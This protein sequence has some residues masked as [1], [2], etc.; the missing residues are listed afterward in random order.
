MTTG[1]VVTDVRTATVVRPLPRPLRLGQM[2]VT[3]REYSAVEV[4]AG[5]GLRGKA[6]CLSREAP[7]ADIVQRL[8]AEHVVGH[9]S[10]DIEAIWDAALRGSAIVGRVGLVR[11]ALGLVDIALWDIAAQRA[12]VPLWSLLGSGNE[13]RPAMLVAAYPT[14][15]RSATEI[16]DEV[17][18]H[19]AQGWPL[20]KISR[21]PDAVLMR[22]VLAQLRDRL[23]DGAGV[24]VDVG[25]GWRDADEALADLAAWDASDLAWVEDPLLPEDAEGCARIRAE[26][27]VAV[28]VGDEVTDPRVLEALMS[29]DALDVLRV[30]VVALGGVTPARQ[31]IDLARRHDLFVSCHVYPEVTV[32]LGPSV[33]TFDRAPGGNAYDPAPTLV[34]GG[35]RF[36]QGTAIPPTAAGLGFDLD[37]GLFRF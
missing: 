16:A 24:V 7:M 6:Y 25:F 21:S 9:D 23:P 19:A 13:P 27:G 5:D 18:D 31:V 8:I 3:R 36:D 26:S 10:A 17:V 32:H 20:L 11:R 33:E 4:R 35:P 28:G 34:R 22:Q 30:D 29:A 2:T 37:P 15:E 1:T 14:Q 12:G